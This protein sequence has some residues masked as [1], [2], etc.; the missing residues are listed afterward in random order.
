MVKKRRG[1]FY[2]WPKAKLPSL[3]WKRKPKLLHDAKVNSPDTHCALYTF[4]WS[5]SIAYYTSYCFLVDLYAMLSPKMLL[6][7]A[8]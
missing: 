6:F 4:Y 3:F 7:S 8:N 5:C 2:R 1:G